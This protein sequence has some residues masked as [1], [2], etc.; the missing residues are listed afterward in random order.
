MGNG[1]YSPNSYVTWSQL[2]T[3]LTRF[4]QPQEYT[5]QNIQYSGWAQGAIQTA[6]ANGWI[7]DRADFTPDAVISRGE[8]V[9]LVNSVLELYRA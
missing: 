3:V 8:L 9:Q 6:V 4:V 7:E 1:R 5:L 2:I